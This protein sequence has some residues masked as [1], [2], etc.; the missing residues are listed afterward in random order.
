LLLA[1]NLAK[2]YGDLPRAEA[3]YRLGLE[4]LPEDP[5][6]LAALGHTYLGLRKAAKAE[7]IAQKLEALA[8]ERASRLRSDILEATTEPLSCSLCGR[9][10]RAPRDLP[11]QSASTIR[12]MPPDD[13]PAGACPR[14]GKIFCISCRKAELQD[15]RFT[16]PDCGE[17]LKLSDN[18]LRYLVR[19][20]IRLHASY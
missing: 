13:S 18:R 12:A 1:G 2:V 14:C 10:W 8:P 5:S 7:S 15:S 17:A 19:E 9:A 20:S 6:L 3:A 4:T 11:A 16:C